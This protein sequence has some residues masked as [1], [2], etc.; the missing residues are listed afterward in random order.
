ML[1][2]STICLREIKLSRIISLMRL[3]RTITEAEVIALFLRTE[4]TSKRWGES[5]RAILATDGKSE[6]IITKA[7]LGN[8]AENAYRAQLFDEFRGYKRR[9]K[10][11]DGF[12][13]D[14]VW[15]RA[16]ITKEELEKALYINWRYW[17]DITDGTR[18]PKDAVAKLHGGGLDPVNEQYFRSV[19]QALRD[20]VTFPEF[21]FASIDEHSLLVVLEGH[22]RLTGYM[23]A[24]ECIPETIEVIVGL[25]PHMREWTEY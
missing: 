23:L 8:E 21:V 11:F 25:S 2:L 1:P 3:L 9:I 13:L 24:P 16:I 18:L 5:I 6:A 4:I 10:L 17:L 7:D 15:S 20:G 22:A 19:A 12:P 14:V